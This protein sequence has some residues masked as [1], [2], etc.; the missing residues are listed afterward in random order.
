M[1]DH[2]RGKTDP[3]GEPENIGPASFPSPATERA[4]AV[5]GLASKDE[6]PRRIRPAAW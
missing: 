2:G 3:P 1:S 4:E 5:N 6:C